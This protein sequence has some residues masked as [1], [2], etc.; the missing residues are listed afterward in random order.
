MEY[1]YKEASVAELERRWD[2]N[3]ANNPDDPR[4]IG[5]KAEYT[6]NNRNGKCRT[7][8]VMYGDD[9]VGEGTLLFSPDCDVKGRVD[10]ADSKDIV[11]VNALRIEREH[12]GKGHISK[13]VRLMEQY[14]GDRGYKTATIGVGAQETRNLG[15]YLH[16][17]YDKFVRYDIEDN[18]ELIL[19]Y[20]KEL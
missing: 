16:W 3:I 18:R 6:A 2:K 7:F 15:I 4:W 10:L 17:G 12:E 1:N 20:S 11:N 19:Y 8:V 14:A 5:W 9:P 13:L